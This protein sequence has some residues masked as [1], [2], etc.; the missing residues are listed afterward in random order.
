MRAADFAEVKIELGA[1]FAGIDT[2]NAVLDAQTTTNG[3]HIEAFS[4]LES[5]LC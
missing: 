3:A 2:A 1:N 4:M 5:L